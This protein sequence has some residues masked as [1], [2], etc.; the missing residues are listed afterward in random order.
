MRYPGPV[1]AGTS[2]SRRGIVIIGVLVV[3][4][5]LSL[6]AY[7]YTDMMTSEYKLAVTVTRNA[8]ARCFAESGVHYAT[9]VLSDPATYADVLGGNPYSNE[10]VFHAQLVQE[11]I[12]SH[13]AGRFSIFSPADPDE[14]LN[15]NQTFRFGVTN[16]G[17]KINPNTL[18][19]L[20]RSGKALNDML[21]KLPDMST[22]IADSI[23]DWLDADDQPRAGG[24][25]NTYYNGLAPPLR[26][27]NNSV[28]TIEELLLVKGLRE[29][30]GLLLGGDRNRNGMIDPDEEGLGVGWSAYLTVY[31]REL[32]VDAT[33]TA[34]IYL[35]DQDLQKVYDSLTAAVGADL[36]AYVVLYRVLGGTTTLPEKAKTQSG[37]GGAGSG[38]LGTLSQKKAK[39][40]IKSIYDLIDVYIAIPPS[41][42]KGETVYWP[43]PLQSKDGAGLR[44]LLPQLLDKTTTS[45]DKDIF[46]RIDVNTAPRAVLLGL[47]GLTEANVD[48]LLS[49]RPG[50]DSNQFGTELY[51]TP[52][53]LLSDA[54]LPVAT[55]KSL[56]K[57][58]TTRAQ[59]F[60][61]QVI[62]YF[63]GSAQFARLEAVIDT[64]GG[65]PRIVSIRDLTELGKGLD[66]QQ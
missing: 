12:L 66:W 14:Q 65:R 30:P 28:D 38:Q 13:G 22:E 15:G 61:M 19:R 11:A 2:P 64:N 23:L 55:L 59:V 46:G 50:I 6:A 37:S 17:G 25:E 27:R 56:E 16:E 62:G 39:S 29:Q 60:R 43:S 41:D 52:A 32:N 24:A 21:L 33:N 35:N 49:V 10:G 34:R 31:S 8:Q 51:Q 3:V 58:I 18:L 42:D 57:Y 44:D 26:A 54:N 63:E 47:P 4:V 20:D 48:K 5:I 45:K 53:W 1:L 7:Q 40:E 9:A 36:A